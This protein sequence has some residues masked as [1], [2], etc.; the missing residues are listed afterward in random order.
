MIS[1]TS[2]AIDIFHY[3]HLRLLEQAKKVSDYH[4]CGL[5][6]DEICLK[7]NG[8]LVMKYEE[9]K[10][11]LNA[12]SCVDEVIEQSEFDPTNNLKFIHDK[13]P[14]AQLIF[15]QGH[16]DWKGMPGTNYIKSIGSKIIKP[17]FYSKLTRS[18]IKNKLNST[19]YSQSYDIESYLLG[20]VSYFSLHNS[21]KANTLASLKPNLEKS[22]IEELFVFTKLQWEKS[23]N[24]I[25]NEIRKKF[26]K[27]IVVRSSTGVEDTY[28]STYAGFFHSELNINA[29]NPQHVSKAIANVIASYSRHELAS[30]K[31]QILVQSQTRD[32]V[33]SGVVFTRNIQNSGPYYLINYDKSSSTDSV[34]SGLVGNKIEIINNIDVEKLSSHWKSLIESVREI[35]NLLHNIALDIEFAIKRNGQVVIFQV[36][37]ISAIQKYGDLP[38]KEVFTTVKNLV[39]QYKSYS[40]SSLSPSHY[41]LSDMCFWNP[42]EIIGDRADNL[43]YSIHRY[44]ILGKPWNTGLIPLGYKKIDRDLVVRIGNKPYIEVETSFESLLPEKLDKEIIKKLISFYCKKLKQSPELHDKIEFEIVHNCFTPTTNDNLVELKKVLSNSEIQIFR[45]SLVNITQHIFDKYNQFKKTDLK[46]LDLLK[47]KREELINIKKNTPVCKKINIILELLNDARELGT[48]QFAR[49]ARLAFIGNQYLRG[50]ISKKVITEDESESFILNIDTVA[51]E[52]NNDFNSVLDKKLSIKDFNKIY[53]HLRPGTYDINKLPYSKEPRYFDSRRS[54]NLKDKNKIIRQIN[55]SKMSEKIDKYLTEYEIKITAEDLLIFIEETTKYRE[56]FKFEFTKNLSLALELLAESGAELG[57][58]RNKLSHLSIESFRGI[59]SSSGIS[60]IVDLWN[61]NIVGKKSID[62]IF[63][64]IALPS[65]IFNEQDFEIIQSHT[66]R[67][68]FITNSIVKGELINLDSND[69]I[70]YSLVEGRIVLL[71]K[72]DPGYD[73]IFSKKIIGLIT[74]FG[75]A[76]SHMAIRAAEFGIPAAIGCGEIIFKDISKRNIVELDCQNNKIITIG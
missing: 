74:R 66:V 49:M 61:S 42:A 56:S 6:S 25:L 23:S 70:D 3:G 37:T 2:V 40:Q 52:L 53:G 29:K 62:Q 26:K 63:K 12:L 34:T 48:P 55:T 13:F 71:E 17:D 14:D 57:F 30:H 27:E 8:N 28:F 20:D 59:A 72:A 10:A 33:Y 19:K 50:L 7:W 64:Y 68:N 51:S 15:F 24:D 46:S 16:Q 75:G 65:L 22:L 1:Y 73:W 45:D 5:Y 21:T 18:S 31:D 9:R 41:T 36:R 4:F 32:V 43:A 44:L 60:E 54:T 76:A 11:I 69:I 38:E 67:P 35:E 39:K 58:D 47:S